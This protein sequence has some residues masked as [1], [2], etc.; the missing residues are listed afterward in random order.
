VGGLQVLA[1]GPSKGIVDNGIFCLSLSLP[2]HKLSDFAHNTLSPW[3]VTSS[4]ATGPTMHG[5]KFPTLGAK[6]FPL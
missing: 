4:K 6:I 3:Y 5:L 2:G 1:E